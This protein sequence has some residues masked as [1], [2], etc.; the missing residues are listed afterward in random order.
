MML[1]K[2]VE[3]FKMPGSVRNASTIYAIMADDMYGDSKHIRRIWERDLNT[4]IDEEAWEELVKTV[5]WSVRY[6]VNKFLHFK[7]IHR[8]Y[9]T[10]I[11]LRKMG[12]MGN[13]KC[14]KCMS[15]TGSYLHLLWD[16]SFVFPFWK[17]VLHVIGGW[18]DTSLPESPRLCL[19]GDRSPSTPN[20]SKAEAALASAG[21]ITA[22]RIILPHWKSQ[23]RPG[24]TEWLT[25]M[26]DTASF[27]NLIASLN[28]GRGRF[29]NVW[30]QF[31]YFIQYQWSQS[32]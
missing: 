11:K 19:I 10:P 21:F 20:V 12:L 13:D 4:R 2:L 17:Q 7:V 6:I 29:Y 23:V 27:E 8:Y 14:W 1:V 18:L 28:D 25:L 15:D 32:L 5:G 16:C 24:F 30:S 26:T 3:Y 9:Y 22:I 31:L